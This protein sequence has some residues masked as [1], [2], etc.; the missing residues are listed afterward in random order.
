M[1]DSRQKRAIDFWNK[2]ITSE[3]TM[4]ITLL[5][6]SRNKVE[7][8]VWDTSEIA[9]IKCHCC[10]KCSLNSA[11]QP[12]QLIIKYQMQFINL[13]FQKNMYGLKCLNQ[14]CLNPQKIR[15]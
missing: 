14:N 5:L 12:H 2:H 1:P 8:W 13:I 3:G 7:T 11:Y 15:K 10:K 9:I 6:G 4:T